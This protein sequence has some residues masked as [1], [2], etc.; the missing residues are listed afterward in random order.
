MW[1][2]T[3]IDHPATRPRPL[4]RGG[5]R[6]APYY[7]REGG[8]IPAGASFRP[9]LG[10][11][12]VLLGFTN[13]DDQAHAPNE[14]DGARQLRGRPAT[15][16]RYWRGCRGRCSE[17]RTSR[18]TRLRDP[19]PSGNGIAQEVRLRADV[20][21]RRSAPAR[22]LTGNLLSRLGTRATPADGVAQRCA[23]RRP[24]RPRATSAAAATM[25]SHLAPR[26]GSRRPSTPGRPKARARPPPPERARGPDHPLGQGRPGQGR[27]VPAR[28]VRLHAARP[29]IGGG[30]RSRRAAPHRRRPGHRQ[31]HDGAADGAQHRPGR[32]GER[33]LRL[34]RARRG[35]PAQPPD[36]HG[37][38]ARAPCRRQAGA[39]KLQDV[40]EE[41]LGTWLARA[42]ANADLLEPAAAPALDRIGRY[43]QNLYLLRGSQT[44]STIENLRALVQR[45]PQSSRATGPGRVHRLP[46]EGADDPRAGDR[47]GE[48]DLRRQRAQGH[49]ARR[50]TCP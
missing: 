25:L 16:V 19:G 34:L 2:L 47:D 40:R 18:G 38:G 1:T 31:D 28:A 43:G 4:P 13:P 36:R 39:V 22:A 6:A 15:I 21:R 41:V 11:P 44:T 48:G 12:V 20:C 26:L 10:L 42:A 8:S 35:V 9:V 14:N 49:R 30:I 17:L 45:V 27:P 46:P 24:G 33:A 50:W 32:P 23:D 7:L 5:V 29:T 3:P 37:V